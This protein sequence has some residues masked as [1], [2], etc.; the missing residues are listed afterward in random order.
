MLTIDH[1]KDDK[2]KDLL[3]KFEDSIKNLDHELYEGC[4]EDEQDKC[5]KIKRQAEHNFVN[6]LNKLLDK[7]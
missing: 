1:L 3:T 4:Y 6:L 5:K 2:L 7:N